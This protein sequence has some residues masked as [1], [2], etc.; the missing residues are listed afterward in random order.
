M[1]IEPVKEVFGQRKMVRQ[2]CIERREIEDK[3]QRRDTSIS[4]ENDTHRYRIISMQAMQ[5]KR[6]TGNK[7]Q[8]SI[9]T[10]KDCKTK[11]HRKT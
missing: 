8:R 11:V 7:R 4:L 3:R 2:R 10:E 9:R 6:K 5:R 1:K